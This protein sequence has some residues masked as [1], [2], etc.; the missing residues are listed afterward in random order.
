MRARIADVRRDGECGGPRGR[1]GPARGARERAGEEGVCAAERAARIR[2]PP[3]PPCAPQAPRPTPSAHRRA[4]RPGTR[5]SAGPAAAG[6]PR[7]QRSP[8]LLAAATPPASRHARAIVSPRSAVWDPSWP[9]SAALRRLLACLAG[10]CAAPAFLSGCWPSPSL[11]AETP[12]DSGLPVFFWPP[13]GVLR[14]APEASLSGPHPRTCRPPRVPGGPEKLAD[15]PVG[16]QV[17]GVLA[18]TAK[19]GIAP[20]RR[21]CRL[22]HFLE[23]SH[24][25]ASLPRNMLI[26]QWFPGQ[27]SAVRWRS[28]PFLPGDPR[29]R[30]LRA[31]CRS[32]A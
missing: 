24:R 1:E 7:P 3:A 19:V 14:S 20:A 2:V 29:S 13:P 9:R 6:R 26:F 27:G 30:A 17:E 18:R 15:A 4:P 12:L 10:S 16:R 8:F 32:E 28:V 21:F 5:V 25:M 23:N 31:R 22:Q 11:L